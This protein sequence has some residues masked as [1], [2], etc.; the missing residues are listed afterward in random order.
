MSLGKI[1]HL[2]KVMT[3]LVN[4]SFPLFEKPLSSKATH[5]KSRHKSLK[6]AIVTRLVMVQQIFGS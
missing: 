2:S 3:F 4:C 5:T 1:H 6:N